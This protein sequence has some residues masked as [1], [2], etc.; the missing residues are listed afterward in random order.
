MR[1]RSGP[2]SRRFTFK[3]STKVDPPANRIAIAG[4]GTAGDPTAGGSAGGGGTIEV[5]NASGT[6]ERFTWPLPVGNW[7]PVS[8]KGYRFK[9]ASS[10]DP[11]Q[12]IVVKGDS[13]RIRGGKANFGYTLDEPA[14]GSVAVRL[15]LGA[16]ATWCASSPAKIGGSYDVP[17]QFVGQ[18]KSPAP[19][20]CP[21]LP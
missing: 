13:I 18:T 19:V 11:I 17:G 15:R 7:L 14:Q 16:G 10:T 20:V 2:T 8:V 5:Y 3:S 21:P 4:A 9:A 1:D 12:R 6:G